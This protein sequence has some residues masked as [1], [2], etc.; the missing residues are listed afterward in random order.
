MDF[1]AGGEPCKHLRWEERADNIKIASAEEGVSSI[2]FLR[3]VIAT[4]KDA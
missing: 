1:L 3:A 4:L 2:G